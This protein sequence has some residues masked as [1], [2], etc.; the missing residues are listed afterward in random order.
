M[1]RNK[2]N[3]DDI[4]KRY[5]PPTSNKEIES[6]RDRFLIL[7]RE[8]H[9]LQE[10]LDNFRTSEPISN[11]KFVSLGYV[12]QLVLTAIY[13]LRGE[14]TSLGIA[15][16]VNALTSKVLDTGTVFLALDRLERGRL[17]SCGPVDTRQEGVDPK[18]VFNVTAE[19]EHMLGDVR[20]A[21]KQLADALEDFA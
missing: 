3:F 4:L 14:G 19:G 11:S 13:L 8:R 6:A 9:E 7:L 5:L 1:R 18:I 21:A 20:V 2:R 16:K 10:A 17:I 12:D 15:D